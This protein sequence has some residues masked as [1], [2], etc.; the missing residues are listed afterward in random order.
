M[1]R[2]LPVPFMPGHQTGHQ[3]VRLSQVGSQRKSPVQDL[4][5]SRHQLARWSNAKKRHIQIRACQAEHW[6]YVTRIG[7]EGLLK[8]AL[9][10]FELQWNQ[11]LL[12]GMPAFQVQFESLRISGEGL[13]HRAALLLR[14]FQ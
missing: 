6:Q 12:K 10:A 9:R 13:G 8:Q 3:A 11:H 1:F 14:K 2:L 5:C 4:S 7:S